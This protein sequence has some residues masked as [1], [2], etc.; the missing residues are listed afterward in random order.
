MV[1]VKT[2]AAV[3]ISVIERMFHLLGPEQRCGVIR[4]SWK[5]FLILRIFLRFL[6]EQLSSS[7]EFG[8]ARPLSPAALD[9]RLSKTN[10]GDEARRIAA[11]IAKLADMTT[12]F[13]DGLRVLSAIK[14]RQSN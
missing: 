11:N 1:V 9:A 4:S 5:Q 3:P 8:T 12:V 14:Q 6:T 7:L 10:G 2:A 13:G